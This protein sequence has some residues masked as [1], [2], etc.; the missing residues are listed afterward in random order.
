MAHVNEVQG[1][2]FARPLDALT[3]ETELLGPSRLLHRMATGG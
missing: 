3:F 1:F 2:L